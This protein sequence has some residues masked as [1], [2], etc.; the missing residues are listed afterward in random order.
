M[1]E[2]LGRIGM[3]YREG[4]KV[5]YIESEILDTEVPA[6]AIWKDEIQAWKPPYERERI[7]E[8]KRMEIL[9]RI[10]AA[11]K[12]ENTPVQI[13]SEATGWVKGWLD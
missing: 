6:V 12:W 1:I 5:M 4:D 9:K 3:E 10:S 11:L 8:E 13:H 2:A 7:T